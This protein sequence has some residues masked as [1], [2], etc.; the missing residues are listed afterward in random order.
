MIL[1]EVLHLQESISEILT[2]LNETKNGLFALKEFTLDN[3]YIVE[4]KASLTI[5]NVLPVGNVP[6]GTILCNV[7][8]KIGDRGAV[9]RASGKFA[10]VVGHSDKGTQ[11]KMPSGKKK[12]YFTIMPSNNWSCSWRWKN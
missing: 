3:L 7:E 2:D 11:I 4:K 8:E 5:G 9:A 1:V 12:S 6:E 10:T